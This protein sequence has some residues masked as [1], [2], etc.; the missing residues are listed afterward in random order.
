M[1]N[2]EAE[3]NELRKEV[4]E[5]KAKLELVQDTMNS[6]LRFNP[7]AEK[8]VKSV[9]QKDNS[10]DNKDVSLVMCKYKKSVLVK[11]K[12]PDKNTTQKCKEQLKEIEGKWNR[13]EQGWLF[14]GAAKEGKSMEENSK[15]IVE[16]L[17][18]CGYEVEVE[19]L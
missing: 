8:E 1:E 14:V 6:L 17:K 15:F 7:M 5:L 4:C 9:Y 12:Y 10:L 3:V 2:L 13:T 16:H 18:E 19:Y 11:S